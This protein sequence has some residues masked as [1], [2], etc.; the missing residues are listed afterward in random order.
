MIN[1]LVYC[2]DEAWEIP[3][4]VPQLEKWNGDRSLLFTKKYEMELVKE[5]TEDDEYYDDNLAFD[6]DD[7]DDEKTTV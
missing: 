5:I 7:E 2:R 4:I 6:D 1:D 3:D